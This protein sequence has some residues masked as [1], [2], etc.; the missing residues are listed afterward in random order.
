MLF[1]PLFLL[2]FVP[3]FQRN[4]SI[5]DIVLSS[6]VLDVIHPNTRGKK[7]AVYP[8]LVIRSP[9]CELKFVFPE[10]GTTLC[11]HP[12]GLGVPDAPLLLP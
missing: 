2:S 5:F 1:V 12:T 6:C 4:Y 11:V 3:W 8:L 10:Q 9:T 7:R